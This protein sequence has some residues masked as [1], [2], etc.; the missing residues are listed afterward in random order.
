MS[1]LA[2]HGPAIPRAKLHLLLYRAQP[3][4]DME[5]TTQ[6]PCTSCEASEKIDNG[7]TSWQLLFPCSMNPFQ[8]LA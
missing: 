4:G 6:M 2:Q 5:S 8:P 1:I 3:R 7:D